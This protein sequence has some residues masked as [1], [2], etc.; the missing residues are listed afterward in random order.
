VP[1]LW[2]AGLCLFAFQLFHHGLQLGFLVP[3]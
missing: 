1:R 3:T 2:Q